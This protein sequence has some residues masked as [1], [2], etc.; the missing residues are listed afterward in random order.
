MMV[1]IWENREQVSLDI[2]C[3]LPRYLKQ[4][5]DMG[6]FFRGYVEEQFPGIELAGEPADWL[7][8]IPEL[9]DELETAVKDAK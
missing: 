8:Y 7:G 1:K 5:A 6:K 4:V 3:Q 2:K 9:Y